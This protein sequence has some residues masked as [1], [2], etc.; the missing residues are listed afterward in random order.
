MKG[1]KGS[2]GRG[3]DDQFRQVDDIRQER[4]RVSPTSLSASTLRRDKL[5]KEREWEGCDGRMQ[6]V[7]SGTP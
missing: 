4:Q 1:D 7:K 6:V 5:T 2:V 3:G